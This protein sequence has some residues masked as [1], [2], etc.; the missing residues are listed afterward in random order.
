LNRKLKEEAV[1]LDVMVIQYIAVDGLGTDGHA[2]QVVVVNMRSMFDE[3]KV[4]K[5]IIFLLTI[6]KSFSYHFLRLSF[7][8]K[9]RFKSSSQCCY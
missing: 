3:V 2:I 7:E 5:N 4:N 9:V 8:Y 1:V 6:K